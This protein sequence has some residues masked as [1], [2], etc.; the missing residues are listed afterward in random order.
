MLSLCINFNGIEL[1]WQSFYI[2]DHACT[3]AAAWTP[4]MQLCE[5]FLYSKNLKKSLYPMSGHNNVTIKTS[6]WCLLSPKPSTSGDEGNHIY[7]A[8]SLPPALSRVTSQWH[9]E[10]HIVM[11]I[12]QLKEQSQ[13]THTEGLLAFTPHSPG[14]RDTISPLP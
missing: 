9:C 5:G 6:P 8:P 11:Y 7:W 14:S 3:M 4:K 2:C 10:V 12:L 1:F 13:N